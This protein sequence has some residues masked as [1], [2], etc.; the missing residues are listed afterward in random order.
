ML[1]REDRGFIRRNWPIWLALI[2]GIGGGIATA[3][4]L[5]AQVSAASAAPQPPGADAVRAVSLTRSTGSRYDLQPSRL[6]L[7]QCLAVMRENAAFAL[8][9]AAAG[10]PI[11]EPAADALPGAFTDALRVFW[12]PDLNKYN[13]FLESKGVQPPAKWNDEKYRTVFWNTSTKTWNNMQ[14]A[15][16]G[17]R[18]TVWKWH[19]A[20]AQTFPYTARN[21]TTIVDRYPLVSDPGANHLTVIEFSFPA[22][23]TDRDGKPFEALAAMEFTGAGDRWILTANSVYDAPEGLRVSVPHP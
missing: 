6:P 21:A 1:I 23:M 5:R 19:G 20:D 9:Q 18:A 7:D 4:M 16:E 2:A 14:I 3:G 13:A 8:G 11:V 17:V 15:S 12:Q 10:L 22:I